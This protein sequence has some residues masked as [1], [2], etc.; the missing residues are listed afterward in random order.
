MK[1]VE[2][3]GVSKS[4]SEGQQDE[5]RR[6]SVLKSVDLT[7][8][9]GEITVL[10]G[11]S[12]CGKT[13]LLHMLAGL[14]EPDAGVISP[15]GI[16]EQC[17][18]VF[19]DHRL[20]PWLTVEENLSL[21]LR[22]RRDLDASEKRRRVLRV[23]KQL[24]LEAALTKMPAALSG[25]MAQRVALGRALLLEPELFLLDEPFAALDALT[26][27]DM[28]HLLLPLTQ[29]K[30]ITTLF[31]THDLAE[32][33]LIADRIIVMDQGTIRTDIAVSQPKP[34]DLYSPQMR[35]LRNTLEQAL[36]IGAPHLDAPSNKYRDTGQDHA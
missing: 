36:D 10:I 14:L 8:Q 6:L 12:G 25:G 35:E 31:V 15:E 19:Q 16:A 5:S 4:Y 11:R 28:Q 24:G 9:A 13:T 21:A 1:T 32:A 3:N 26:R 27:S 30:P 18:V 20:L 23:L 17:G 7:L 34:R 22:H 29:E 2:L 33:C